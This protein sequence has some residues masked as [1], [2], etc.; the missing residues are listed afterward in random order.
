MSNETAKRV[1]HQS[2]WIK[3]EHIFRTLPGRVQYPVT[4]TMFIVINSKVIFSNS[5]TKIEFFGDIKKML[6][7]LLKTSLQKMGTID[8]NKQCKP[9]HIYLFFE[10]RKHLLQYIILFYSH[11]CIRCIQ[12]LHNIF[13]SNNQIYFHTNFKFYLLQREKSLSTFSMEL[14]AINRIF[15]ES[16]ILDLNN[17]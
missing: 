4:C 5:G 1:E 13:I 14:S 11:T 7:F 17:V 9:F 6:L 15:F 3:F 2:I 12:I 16:G 10:H 8:R